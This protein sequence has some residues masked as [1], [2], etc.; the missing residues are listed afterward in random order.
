MMAPG[1]AFFI[2]FGIVV[3]FVVLICILSDFQK[4]LPKK[5]RFM[6]CAH[7]YIYKAFMDMIAE[8]KLQP[9][10]LVMSYEQIISMLNVPELNIRDTI[11]DP[12]MGYILDDTAFL[13]VYTHKHYKDGNISRE[14]FNEYMREKNGLILFIPKS[15]MDYRKLCRYFAN[16]DISQTN[17]NVTEKQ[18][19]SLKYLT[20]LIHQVQDKHTRTLQDCQAEMDR[21]LDAE[22]LKRR[23]DMQE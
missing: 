10:T 11:I 9:Y 2:A 12:S 7:Y 8:R 1:L 3:F 17:G 23:R 6:T 5:N 16:F 15:Y 14:V 4:Y 21:E 19:E 20:D 13:L 22:F 18:M